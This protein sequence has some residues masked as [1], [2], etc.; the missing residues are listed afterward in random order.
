MIALC[1]A[2]G[3]AGWATAS[4]DHCL[5]HADHPH[6][7]LVHPTALAA[8]ALGVA[9]A[10]ALA[11]FG[12]GAWRGARRVARARR[13]A[14][15]LRAGRTRALAADVEVI[16]TERA[17]SFALAGRAPLVLVSSA[18]VEALDARALDAVLAHERAHLA[19]RDP[20]VLAIA[21]AAA[22][23]L[24]GRVR[25]DVLATLALA[26]EQACDDAAAA[27]AGDRLLVARALLE[28]AALVAR[29]HE[30]PRRE[31]RALVAASFADG[32]VERRVEHLLRDAA[33]PVSRDAAAPGASLRAAL[34]T[35]AA[36]ALLALAAQPVHHAVE[37][38]LGLLAGSR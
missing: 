14:A 33:A 7:C 4:G 8:P 29:S 21:R 9:L 17:F 2:P 35:A 38:V 13:A 24:P 26:A 1:L 34:A 22:R 37:H 12:A 19:R 11:L 15:R 32:D 10:A 27:C 18:L 6:L 16:E 20:L 25:E 23:A 30:G 3:V 36:L 28:V 31:A 5:R